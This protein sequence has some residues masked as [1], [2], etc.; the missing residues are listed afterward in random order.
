MY[1]DIS[2]ADDFD[3]WLGVVSGG[4]SLLIRPAE[5]NPTLPDIFQRALSISGRLGD[6]ELS[7]LV[8]LKSG[9]TWIHFISRV[10]LLCTV[11]LTQLIFWLLQ[12]IPCS[13]WV[14]TSVM[15][16]ALKGPAAATPWNQAGPVG[17]WETMHVGLISIKPVGSR[18][19]ASHRAK[20]IWKWG[21]IRWHQ[22][23]GPIVDGVKISFNR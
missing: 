6:L 15:Y 10:C 7:V 5:T 18:S 9:S 4:V 13:L 11:R 21:S 14:R 20:L 8:Y 19:L 2:I 1:E 22:R 3:V 12:W 23:R 17:E 16:L